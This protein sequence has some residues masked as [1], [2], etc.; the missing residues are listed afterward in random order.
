MS[1]NWISYV[2]SFAALI[3][4]LYAL[5][6]SHRSAKA[7]EKNAAT[8]IEN[9]AIN[10]QRYAEEQQKK[11]EMKNERQNEYKQ[12][13]AKT[14][15]D[16]ANAVLGKYQVDSPFAKKPTVIDWDSFKLIPREP[17]FDDDILFDYFSK[18]ERVQI[19]QAWSDLNYLIKKYG[20]EDAVRAGIGYAGTV[21]GNFQTLS[22]TLING[23]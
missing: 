11:Q 8:A 17:I 2:I 6:N 9:L 4:S 1:W 3:V 20:E 5:R 7:A 18:E 14:C 21:I 16:V 13:L 12:R 23:D 10:K 19:Q 15:D 22:R